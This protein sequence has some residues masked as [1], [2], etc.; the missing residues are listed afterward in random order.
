MVSQKILYLTFLTVC[1]LEDLYKNHIHIWLTALFGLAAAVLDV[2]IYL[3][4]INSVPWSDRLASCGLGIMVLAGSRLFRGGI[5]TGDGLF[6]LVSGL[7]L[8]FEENLMILYTGIIVC[9]VYCL[10]LYCWNRMRYGRD[11]RNKKVP[12]LPFV[13]PGGIWLVVQYVRA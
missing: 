8:S 7:M 3:G 1:G 2:Y 11:I 13:V 4:G 10:M 5:G 9:G 6:F 12:F